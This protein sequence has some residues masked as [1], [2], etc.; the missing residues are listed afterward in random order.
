MCSYRESNKCYE[1]RIGD[2]VQGLHVHTTVTTVQ[3]IHFWHTPLWVHSAKRKVRYSP[4]SRMDDSEPRQLLHSGRGS[5]IPGS[6]GASRWSPPVLQGEAVKIYLAS[7]SS[8][9][10]AMWLNRERRRV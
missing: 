9:I 6:T 7:Y 2:G 1:N 10:C 4:D 5:V 8:D 3:F